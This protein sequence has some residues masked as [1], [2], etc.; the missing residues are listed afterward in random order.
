MVRAC[1][2]SPKQ[3]ACGT[4]HAHHVAV[5][6]EHG[7]ARLGQHPRE[8]RAAQPLAA[9]HVE[10]DGA[11]AALHAARV[12]ASTASASAAFA[13]AFAAAAVPQQQRLDLLRGAVALGDLL[14]ALLHREQRAQRRL[15]EERAQERLAQEAREVRAFVRVPAEPLELHRH[16]HRDAPL[17]RAAL[18][19]RRGRAIAVRRALLAVQ[20]APDDRLAARRDPPLAQALAH[21]RGRRV[22]A[23]RATVALVLAALAGPAAH[24]RVD[25]AG[26]CT[27]ADVGPQATAV[28]LPA[29]EVRPADEASCRLAAEGG[30]GAAARPARG[31][32]HYPRRRQQVRILV[33][34]RHMAG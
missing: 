12:A 19:G 15:L 1:E 26:A 16:R 23:T 22:P 18:G 5:G 4:R 34:L 20:R 33:G 27:T 24:R 6:V 17:G 32:H 14:G 3:A 9:A 30:L 29:R 13:F 8:E 31:Q 2:G 10:H 11:A 25:R 21:L 7:D 28:A